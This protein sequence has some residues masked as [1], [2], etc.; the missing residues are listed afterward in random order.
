MT[1]GMFVN[2]EHRLSAVLNLRS[3][4]WLRGSSELALLPKSA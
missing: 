4:A 1:G 2:N 3:A